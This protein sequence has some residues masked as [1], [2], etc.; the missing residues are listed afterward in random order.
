MFAL[1]L[2]CLVVALPST[3]TSHLSLSVPDAQDGPSHQ[4]HP[5]SDD[6]P[7]DIMLSPDNLLQLN[8][9]GGQG[10]SGGQGHLHGTGGPGGTGL[11]P[12]VHISVQQLTVPHLPATLAVEQTFIQASQNIAQ[13]PP[14]SRIFQGRR[15]M[16]Q[17]MHDFFTSNKGQNIYVLHG[18]GG[19]GKTQIALKFINESTSRTIAT[20][21]TGLKNIAVIKHCGNSQKDG[22]LWLRTKVEEWL[23]FLDSADD[24]SINLHDFIPQCT[25]GNIIITS[26]NP[27]LSVYAGAQS[28]VSDMTE[29][30]AVALLLRSAAQEATTNAKQ[31]AI[32]I[33]K[34]LHYLP[35]AI[36]QAGSFIAKSQ[37]LDGYLALY[38]ENQTHLL[39]MKPVQ[40][41][42]HYAQ[43]VYTT[44][45]MSFN[46]LSPPATM[47]LQHCSFLHYNMI[48]EEIFSHASKYRFQSDGP[49][50]E[51]LQ[52]ALEV[53]SYFVKP[54]GEWD[55]LKFLDVTN[56]IQA[57]SL[58]SFDARRR[59]FSMHE[60][61]HTWSQ[62][63]VSDRERC[64]SAVGAILGMAISADPED[65][66]ELA[67][68]RLYPHVEMA[69]QHGVKIAVDFRV[70]YG[71]IFRVA[72]QLKESRKLLEEV[73]EEQKQHLGINHLNTIFTMGQLAQTYGGLGEHHKVK[74]LEVSV[75]EK[76]KQLLGQDHPDTLKTLGNLATTYT[77][78]GEHHKARELKISVLEKRKQ[79]LGQDHPHTLVAMGNLAATYTDLGEHHK[80]KE[81]K[82][83]VLEKRKQILGQDHPHTLIA[84]GNLASTYTD[85]G[86][87]HKAKEL[88]VSVLEKRKQI[89]GQDDPHTLIAMRNLAVTY[90]DLG[91]HHKAK[92]LEVSVLEKQKQILGQ[93]HPD[94]LRTMG[95]LA[96]TYTDL[97]EHHKAK[98]LEVS[99]LETRK[100]ILGQDHPDT[101][102]AIDLGEHHKAK[103]LKVSVLEKQKQILGQDHPDTLR[104]MGNLA[105]TYTDLGEHH[106]A[107]ELEVSV[108]EKQR[109][110][111]GQDHPDTLT[112]MG[113]L[114]ATY[115]DVEEYHNAKELEVFVLGKQKQILGQDHRD[116]LRTMGNLASTYSNL[117][118]HQKARELQVVLLE[119]QKQILGSNHPDTLQ[120]IDR[121]A[122]PQ[123][124]HPSILCTLG[125]WLHQLYLCHHHAHLISW[126]Q[127]WRRRNLA[128][129]QILEAS[130]RDINQLD[131]YRAS[132]VP[133]NLTDENPY[134]ESPY[135]FCNAFF[136]SYGQRGSDGMI[137][138][139]DFAVKYGARVAQLGVPTDAL[140]QVLVDTAENML[141]DWYTVRRQNTAWK[142]FRYI[143]T[144]WVDPSG[145]TGLLMREAS[146]AW[147]YALGDFVVHQVAIVLDKS[148]A[149]V[150]KCANR[151]MNFVNMWD[152]SV[153]SNG[154]SG[155][156]QRVSSFLL[157]AQIFT[158]ICAERDLRLQPADRMQPGRS[159]GA[160][161]CARDGQQRRV[162]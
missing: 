28:H 153:T 107:K 146:R 150:G 102:I 157:C 79:I 59:L 23:L 45:Q 63:T 10:G 6:S 36:V 70:Q 87:H 62:T 38:T 88:K 80:A 122:Q 3:L 128:T 57:Y 48:S 68:L 125:L 139:G 101:L 82:V 4:D 14:P 65:D 123:D 103:E 7:R 119:K 149:D 72:R 64:I 159:R 141:P 106:K 161:V 99:V 19:A 144:G 90:R 140:Y 22:L 133:V 49:S 95:N 143:P 27:G 124:N 86:E 43:T 104:T 113:N 115:R 118:E 37:D 120:T 112:A 105:V 12:T 96:V 61:V 50:K 100:Q 81:L 131:L 156:A 127:L 52:N 78:L 121:L 137:L 85:L 15:N 130:H 32:E 42:D 35:L 74:E 148:A 56:E 26:R 13:C 129:S 33:V 8:I 142:T 51:E 114:A 116:T 66:I 5:H 40:G 24:P 76:R 71:L 91:E 94:T 162:L 30:D 1:W 152:P 54:N 145:S 55:S 58:L 84:M 9:T 41:H 46:Q 89:L 151:S 53:L 77:N 136:C 60:L 135:P 93:D 34:A 31:I 39:S 160:L 132:L 69:V 154:F 147:E 11:G 20:I 83:S 25:H 110:I 138:L 2:P 158:C 29:Q 18:L 108:L 67:T 98:E 109:Q 21:E 97:G 126:L 16:L 17:K 111:L 75:L 134:W 73:L 92:E 155:F 47:F 44:W 117:G